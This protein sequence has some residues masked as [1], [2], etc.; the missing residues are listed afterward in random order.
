MKSSDLLQYWLGQKIKINL[1]TYLL[2]RN[3]NFHYIG[4]TCTLIETKSSFQC[5]ENSHVTVDLKI[6][7]NENIKICTLCLY[8]SI[9]NMNT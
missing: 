3:A 5:T 1:E 4:H 6:F 9:K 2:F 8:I 7:Q